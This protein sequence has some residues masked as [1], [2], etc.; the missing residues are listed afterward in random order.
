[1]NFRDNKTKTIAFT[2]VM[3]AL[4]N[5][6]S[7][8]PFVIPISL[9]AFNSSIHFTQL[10]ILIS[11]ILG[12]PWIGLLTGAIGG[13]YMSFTTEIPFIVGGLAILGAASGFF[14]NKMK[15][16]PL[17]SG[18]L[19]WAIQAP[20]VFVTD[21][22]WFS[23]VRA[24]PSA[25][26]LSTLTIILSALTIEVLLASGLTTIIISYIKRHRLVGNSS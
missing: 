10:P 25:V 4:S 16:R 12:G 7:A 9:G 13:L 8:P 19:A 21:Y 11:G 1:M 17:F 22:I 15:I 14:A 6:L 23:S 24:M 2:A 20:Y 18:I 5:I 26:A 3:A